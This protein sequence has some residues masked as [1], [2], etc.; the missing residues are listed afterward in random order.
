[1]EKLSL[2]IPSERLIGFTVPKAGQFFVCDHDEVWSVSLAGAASLTETDHAPYEFV[3]QRSDF[4]GWGRNENEVKKAGITEIEYKFDP[5]ADFVVVRYRT[6]DESGEI[7]F[8]TFSGDWFAASLSDDG[9][10]LVLAEPYEL[11]IF[12]V[13]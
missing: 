10:L 11:A 8:R 9:K 3:E 1:V 7:E 13:T 5:T 12:T 2:T 4:V 6:G